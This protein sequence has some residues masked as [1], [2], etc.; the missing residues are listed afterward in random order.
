MIVLKKSCIFAS[1][2]IKR[3]LL[4]WLLCWIVGSGICFAHEIDPYALRQEALHDFDQGRAADAQKK[5]IQAQDLFVEAQ[6]W[7]MVSMC[8]YERAIDY[9]NVG[10]LENMATQKKELQYLYERKNS[11]IVAYNYHS[12]ASGYYSYVD[13]IE[14]AIQH[15][16]GAIHALEQI[17]DPYAYNIV[18]VWSYYNIAFFYDMYFD[19]PQVD[20][21]RYYLAR[22]REVLK[23]SRTWKESIEG[24]ISVVDLEAWQEYYEKDYFQAEQ[25]MLEVIAMIDTVA[26]VSPNTVITE[27]GEAYKFLSMIYEEQGKWQKALDYKQ[28][29]IENNDLRYD[30]DKR[31]VLQDIQTK[32]EVEKQT[33]QMEKLAAENKSNRWIMVALWLLLVAMVLC[34]WLLEMRRKNI[35]AKF[36]EA[37]LEADNMRQTINALESKTDVD[38]LVILVDELVEQLLN[39]RKREYVESA[40]THLRNL[41]LNHIQSLLSHAK[42]LTTMDKRYILCFAAGMTVE[43]IADLMSLEPASVYTVRYR[44]RKKFSS[45]Y[46]FPH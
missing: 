24:L 42:K 46:P 40:V 13:S 10:D 41:D 4:I 12:V 9:M 19:P 35:E 23:D 34:Y 33:L 43:N 22:S 14:L 21:V 18:P 28:K 36:Y 45:E 3:G 38:P 1:E 11:A 31:R 26:K 6:N 30:V 37:A 27:R 2:M 7:D 5:L 15:G 39:G 16:W 29:L 25:M 8:L 17:D 32:Y 20:S 44:L